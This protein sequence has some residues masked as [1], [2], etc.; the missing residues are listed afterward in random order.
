MIKASATNIEATILSIT[1]YGPYFHQLSKRG[2]MQLNGDVRQLLN[3]NWT[4]LP[5]LLV[6]C[7]Q[8]LAGAIIINKNNE[9][10]LGNTVEV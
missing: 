1:H 10:V 7:A 8:L 6:A 4:F 2:F 3:D 9:A 5:Q